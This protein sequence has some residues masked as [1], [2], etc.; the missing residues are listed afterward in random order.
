MKKV[1]STL[2]ILIFSVTF[3]M[4]QGFGEE[5]TRQLDLLKNNLNLTEVQY[6]RIGQ[7]IDNLVQ[8]ELKIK[9][10]LKDSPD[11]MKA[12]L[13]EV[14]RIKIKNLKG[15]LTKDQIINFDRLELEEKL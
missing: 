14:R 12:R 5:T 7:T 8:E 6:K 2:L 10:I 11:A 13:D 3:A 4:A 1:I 15:G 9:K